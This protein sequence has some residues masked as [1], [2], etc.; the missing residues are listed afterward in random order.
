MARAFP[1][2]INAS[3]WLL[4][5]LT[6]ANSQATKK[7]FNATSAAI[8]ASFARTRAGGSQW[9]AIASAIGKL[10]KA[11]NKRR[12][13]DRMQSPA[14]ESPPG[15]LPAGLGYARDESVRSQLTEGEPG[16]A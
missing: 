14:S 9:S 3:S 2:S 12:F 7:P 13:M 15:R 5:T 11:E 16:D 4:R 8:A 6:I 10:L 1:S